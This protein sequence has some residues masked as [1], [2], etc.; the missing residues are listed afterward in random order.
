MIRSALGRYQ[1]IWTFFHFK[2][3]I[4][5]TCGFG[6][7]MHTQV[8]FRDSGVVAVTT[9][10]LFFVSVQIDQFNI[11]LSPLTV[12]RSHSKMFYLFIFLN[13][14]SVLYSLIEGINMCGRAD[15][16]SPP[17]T[18][19]RSWNYVHDEAGTSYGDCDVSM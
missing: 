9:H 18:C 14:P 11:P 3:A 12:K 4:R 6:N 15:T 10:T 5:S 8:S 7:E 13:A 2:Q 19:P 17:D 16:L 1:N